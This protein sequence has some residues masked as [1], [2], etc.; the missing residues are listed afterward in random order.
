LAKLQDFFLL[1]EVDSPAKASSSLEP[2][3][4]M[5]IK[6]ADFV[7][8]GDLD[9]PHIYD[10]TM[11]LK[12]NQVVGIVGDIGSGKSLLAAI[13]GQLKK[14][15]GYVVTDGAVCGFLSQEPWFINATLKE[16]IVFGSEENEKKYNDAIRISG[17]TR[18]L[19]L[20]SNG[21][22]SYVNELNLSPSQR[23]RLSL[24]RLI[25]HDPDIVLMEDFLGYHCLD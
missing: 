21:D 1:P 19:M 10:L 18:D 20:L 17:L 22:E 13:M 8:D 12:R 23:Q 7:W 5:E 9:H 16:N 24:A 11:T 25:Y 2:D 6:D 15:K 14:K 3:V 4:C